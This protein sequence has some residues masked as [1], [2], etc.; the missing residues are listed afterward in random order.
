MTISLLVDAMVLIVG[1][2]S[3]GMAR[4]SNTIE[5]NGILRP[6]LR[7]IAL[8]RNICFENLELVAD[9]LGELQ[10]VL[11]LSPF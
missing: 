4:V 8:G 11:R 7:R 3:R 6:H 10:L 2:P 1:A 9:T 5:S